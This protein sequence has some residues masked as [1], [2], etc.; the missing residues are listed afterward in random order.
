MSSSRTMKSQQK[1]ASGTLRT[2]PVDDS[3]GDV[4]LA[5]EL[6]KEV[7]DMTFA[8]VHAYSMEE[9]RQVLSRLDFDVVLLD[10]CLPESTGAETVR[11]FRT[12]A[13]N[14][15]VVVLTGERS[16]DLPRLAIHASAQEYL[17]K[18]DLTSQR[19]GRSI[20]QALARRASE[21]EL[22]RIAREAASNEQALQTVIAQDVDGLVVT[23]LSARIL[24][25]NPA[26]K[27]LLACDDGARIEALSRAPKPWPATMEVSP[28][29]G[30]VVELRISTSSWRGEPALVI[31]ARDVTARKR[32][33]QAIVRFNSWLRDQRERLAQLACIDPLTGSFNRNGIERLLAGEVHRSARSSRRIAALVIRCDDFPPLDDEA[34]STGGDK[35]LIEVNERLRRALRPG[36]YLARLGG[37]DFLVLIE[38]ERPGEALEIAET[39]RRSV[40]QAPIAIDSRSQRVTIS[41]AVLAVPAREISIDD[42]LAEAK[43]R[44]A[45]GGAGARDRVAGGPGSA[46]AGAIPGEA[47]R[48]EIAFQRIV[49]VGTGAAEA[50]ELAARLRG[51]PGEEPRSDWASVEACVAAWRRA[52]LAGLR[53]HFNVAAAELTRLPLERLA[54]ALALSPCFEIDP[55]GLDANDAALRRRIGELR[56][57]GAT[58]ALEHATSAPLETL[59]DLAPDWIKIGPE[60]G[61]AAADEASLVRI[62]RVARLAETFNCEVISEGCDERS[63]FERLQTLGVE[64]AQGEASGGWI[65]L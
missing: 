64:L 35:I 40:G 58:I 9:A 38:E 54:E 26:A 22:Q 30:T 42:L 14:A 44:L 25:C 47:E 10:L 48:L 37:N 33:E 28:A 49:R 53:P 12:L 43:E 3:P 27:R 41:V 19:L 32:S 4:R 20:A 5:R 55:R 21:L 8:V 59:I 61:A 65:E 56:A 6:L 52:E 34:G 51:A 50:C 57:A 36:D 17:T 7:P 11:Q 24:F 2:L 31:S 16:A 62:A 13:P 18:D 39:L 45:S 1:G 46:P 60:F 15:A 23:D 29:A 63:D